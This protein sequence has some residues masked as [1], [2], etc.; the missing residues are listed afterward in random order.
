MHKPSTDGGQTKPSVA[1]RSVYGIGRPKMTWTDNFKSWTNLSF[2]QLSRE[3]R[4]M[5][6]D[7][8]KVSNV[9]IEDSREQTLL[10]RYP[11]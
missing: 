11:I 1:R 4:E 8:T 6:A 10:F 9:W 5:E 7:G 3:T 2:D